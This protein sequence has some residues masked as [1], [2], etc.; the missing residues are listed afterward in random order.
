MSWI[1]SYFPQ[2][3]KLSVYGLIDIHI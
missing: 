3:L 1:I 2:V